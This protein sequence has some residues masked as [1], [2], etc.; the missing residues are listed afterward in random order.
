[1]EGLSSLANRL[2][3]KTRYVSIT[4]S[5]GAEGMGLTHS[6]EVMIA[7]KPEILAK[8]IMEL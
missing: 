2:P 6:Y 7:S 3:Y 8:Y 4:T 5:I 1:M